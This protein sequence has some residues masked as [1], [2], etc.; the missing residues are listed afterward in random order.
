MKMDKQALAKHHFWILLGVFGLFAVLLIILVPILVGAEIEEKENK[1]KGV[2]D[3]LK[4]NSNPTTDAYTKKQQEEI[5]ILNGRRETLWGEMYGYQR[6]IL[7]FPPPLQEKLKDLKFGDDID[8][9]YLD[10]YRRGIYTP[11]YE[12]IVGIIKPTE[13]MPNWQ[14]VLQPVKWKETQL[15][16][17]EEMWLSLEDLCVRREVLKIIHD[18]NQGPAAFK[19]APVGASEKLPDSNLG[20]EFSKRFVNRWYQIDLVVNDKGRGNYSFG[21]K[22]KNLSGRRRK[23][24]EL[25]LEIYLA[26]D[27]SPTERSRPVTLRY[28]LDPLA[29]GEERQ[30]PEFVTDLNQRPDKIYRLDLKHNLQTVPVKYLQQIAFGLDAA[31]HRMADRKLVMAK[32]SKSA[33]TA[34]TGA[35]GNPMGGGLPKGGG[36]NPMG[37]M[38][39]PMGGM[40]GMGGA[41]GADK[42][43]ATDNGLMKSRYIELTDQVRRIPL[44]VVMVIDQSNAPDVLT[45]FTN[46]ARMRFQITQYHWKRAYLSAGALANG[47]SESDDMPARGDEPSKPATGGGG[48]FAPKGGGM[49]PMGGMGGPMGGM[50]GPIGGA[51]TGGGGILSGSGYGGSG[52]SGGGSNVPSFAEQPPMSLVEITIYGIANI[53]ERPKPPKPGETP[54]PTTAITTPA[55]APQSPMSPIPGANS[56]TKPAAPAAPS[57][58]S[59]PSKPAPDKAA[60]K[61]GNP[62][63]PGAKPGDASTKQSNSKPPATT[64]PKPGEPKKP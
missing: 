47:S 23:P 11:A 60:P 10:Q 13:Y 50:G 55:P 59:S 49:S 27:F 40:A 6:D 62:Q 18:A 15:L 7:T 35:G 63:S 39:G 2:A 46:S 8:R 12:D 45:A 36:M 1:L 61:S 19:E 58:P 9:Q 41:G 32:F 22:V 31:G 51:G 25:A 14:T 38:G 20:K 53:Y 24:Y 16:T 29:A 42:G 44:A 54:A 17:S 33:E 28:S 21:G 43:E 56:S 57:S 30:L 52:V 48:A 3:Q 26:P 64:G 37:G 4:N 34:A 5:E